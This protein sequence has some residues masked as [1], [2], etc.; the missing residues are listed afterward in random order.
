MYPI[1]SVTSNEWCSMNTDPVVKPKKQ[2]D[3]HKIVPCCVCKKKMRSN[4]LKRHIDAMHSDFVILTDMEMEKV[5]KK[6]HYAMEMQAASEHKLVMIGF[7]Q[8]VSSEYLLKKLIPTVEECLEKIERQIKLGKVIN[9]L[10]LDGRAT[11][12]TLPNSWEEALYTYWNIEL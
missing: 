9:D 1:G 3:Y 12:E 11:K 2:K 8:G 5:I 10:M 4:D 7:E 6:R